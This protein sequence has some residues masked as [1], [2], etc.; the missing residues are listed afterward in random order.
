[1]PYQGPSV[2]GKLALSDMAAAASS[3]TSV[4][5]TDPSR[6]EAIRLLIVLTDGQEGEDHQLFESVE[7]PEG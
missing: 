1:M 7:D 3:S 5:I 6:V 4:V 2:A